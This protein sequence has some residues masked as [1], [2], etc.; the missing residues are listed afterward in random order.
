MG[1]LPTPAIGRMLNAVLVSFDR[2]RRHAA[3][4]A[5]GAQRRDDRRAAARTAWRPASS[6]F[7]RITAA[8]SRSCMRFLDAGLTLVRSG[9]SLQEAAD[10]D[11]RATA[12]ANGEPVPGFGHR[13]HTRDPRAAR[14]FQ[15]A[16]ELELEGEHV[17]M[18]RAV[19]LRR[20]RAPAPTGRR[21]RSTSTARSPRSAATSAS[22]TS[23]AT[24]CSSS[25]AC[26]ASPRTRTKSGRAS[27]R[28]GRSIRRITSTTAPAS[29]GC[30]T[31]AGGT[32]HWLKRESWWALVDRTTGPR[33]QASPFASEGG[34]AHQ[35][36]SNQSQGPGSGVTAGG[37]TFDEVARVIEA[38]E[39]G[40]TPPIL[41]HRHS[42]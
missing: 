11:R 27:I 6:A 30:P 33:R 37:R 9:A 18:I 8:T 39:K 14:L 12:C 16:L 3:V 40:S 5:G 4:D 38:V 1:E 34:D 19:E 15:M 21:C 24:R 10:D 32:S 13:F 29:A 2:S 28:C 23:S 7:G 36:G 20:W 35:S 25:R 31:S 22:P 17:Q 41:G 26:P 42:R